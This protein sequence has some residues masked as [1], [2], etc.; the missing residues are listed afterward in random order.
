MGGSY[1]WGWDGAANWVKV[2][3][4]A[5]GHLQVDV[6]TAGGT[7]AHCMGWTGAAWTPLLVESLANANLRTRLYD[8]VN[9]IKAVE[10]ADDI[11]D[12][13]WGLFTQAGIRGWDGNFWK[14][15]NVEDD[16][17]D[18][19]ANARASLATVAKLY[20]YNGATWDRLRTY[21]TGILKVGRAEIDSTTVRR[22]AAGAVVA[23][24][25]NLYWISCSPDGP[26]SEFELTDAI[27]GGG[28]VVFDHF[29]ADRHSEIIHLDPPMKFTAGIWVEKFD[30]IHS[31]VFCYV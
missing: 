6:I 18:A 21:G 14:S 1:L 3:V 29:D 5:A 12:A 17:G 15:V 22:V 11:V 31:L 16:A 9:P 8:G 24:A 13:N 27:A 25:H 20:G 10:S 26:G 30:H 7:A 23:G 4:D 2:R 19:L 28:A